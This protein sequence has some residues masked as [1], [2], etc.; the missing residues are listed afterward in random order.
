MSRRSGEDS[1]TMR[2]LFAAAFFTLLFALT[3]A[4]DPCPGTVILQNQFAAPNPNWD[5]SANTNSKATLQNG[6]YVVNFLNQN[7]ARNVLYQGDVYG[8]VNLCVTVSTP[9]TDKP[10]DQV[11]GLIFWA[12][13]YNSYY[14]FLINPVSGQWEVTHLAGNR[15]LYPSPFQASTAIKT[16]V[17]TSNALQVQMRG[18]TATLFINGTQ[19]GT[20]S[21]VAPTGGGQVGF[22]VQSASTAI[23]NFQI[24]DFSLSKP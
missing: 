5:A 10:L 8:D 18:T 13:D 3:A 7:I 6:Q 16:G 1:S 11:G 15:W 19:V 4:A 24:S 2:K 14:T 12:T 20:V 23:S 9:A 21:G 22:Y 17:G